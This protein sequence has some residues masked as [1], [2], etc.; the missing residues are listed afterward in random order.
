V[1]GRMPAIDRYDGPVFR[2]LRKYLREGPADV[3]TVL[4]LS[5]K[6]GLIESDREIPWYDHRLSKASLNRLRPRVLKM[7]RHVLRSRQWRAV[8]LCAGREYRSA[9][10]GLAELIPEGVGLDLLPGG[11]GKRLTALRNWLRQ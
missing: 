11:L 10:N 6:F 9:L 5:A 1:K 8:G 2:V 4:I 3:P 7:A